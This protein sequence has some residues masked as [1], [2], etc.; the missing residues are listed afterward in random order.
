MHATARV[1]FCG[2]LFLVSAFRELKGK[3]IRYIMRKHSLT[4]LFPFL[5]NITLL[6]T[7]HH[8]DSTKYHSIIFVTSRELSI[9]KQY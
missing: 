8:L 1:E 5:F 7:S 3:R 2:S 4:H 6:Q 9:A